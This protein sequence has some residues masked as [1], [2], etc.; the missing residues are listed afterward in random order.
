[1][2]PTIV[3]VRPLPQTKVWVRYADGVEGE[4]DLSHLRGRGVFKSW[5]VPGAFERVSIDPETH[6]L[7]W[8]GNIDLD[9]YVLRSSI[10]GE[11]LP[12]QGDLRAAS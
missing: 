5:D 10:T 1:M 2:Y 4:I 12:G 3:E 9:P 11:P 8:P 6:T 7:C